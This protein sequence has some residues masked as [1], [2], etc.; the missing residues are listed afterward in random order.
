MSRFVLCGVMW[1]AAI[2]VLPSVVVGQTGVLTT[3]EE[4][5]VGKIVAATA[6]QQQWLAASLQERVRLAEALGEEGARTMA[7]S[8]GY[9]ALYDG[10]ESLLPQGPDQVYRAADSRVIVY[11]AKGGSGQLGHAYGHPQGTTEWAVES[12]KR[13]L[14]STKAGE[15][16][17]A[18]AQKI[19]A[20]ATEGRL[21]VHV[22]RTKHVLGE[23][24][25]AVLEG[26]ATTTDDASRL[27]RGVLDDLV[28]AGA[29]AADDALRATD[30]IARASAEGGSVL[31]TVS[32]AALP[33]AVA[34][35]AGFRV[36][37]SMETERQFAAGEISVQQRE[38]DHAKNAA[39]M[40]GGWTGAW[41]GAEIG[42]TG[43][44]L[45]GSAIAPGPGTA[46]GGVI[47]GVAG[48]VTGYFCGEAAAGAAAEWTM[49]Q[50]HATGTTIGDSARGAWMSTAR[51]ASSATDGVSRTWNWAW[52]R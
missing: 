3:A 29:T 18:A 16:E 49:N 41:A 1:L 19:L 35:D 43:G 48:G 11:E 42:A 7:K 4:I 51:A 21:E 27:A 15:V 17:R 5:V 36:H 52:G 2:V 30:D 8:K 20:A 45:A 6:R 39:G 40:A 24:T 22:I 50:V 31:K 34:V 9:E 23:P 14:R 13:V 44:G 32:K 26:V 10:L 46:V 33:V 38:V 47:G 12:A 28:R 37:D 25:A